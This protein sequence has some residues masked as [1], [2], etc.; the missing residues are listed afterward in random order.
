MGRTLKKELGQRGAGRK[1]RKQEEPQLITN[2]ASEVTSHGAKKT[3]GGKIRQRIAKRKSALKE[4][5][6][7]KKKG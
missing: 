6:R 5:L 4:A 3:M 1:S 7:K 2:H